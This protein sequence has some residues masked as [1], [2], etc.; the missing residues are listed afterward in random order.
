MEF[1]GLFANS[2]AIR[3]ADNPAERAGGE[4]S[5]LDIGRPEI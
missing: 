4:V 2:H 5:P 1:S 3:P